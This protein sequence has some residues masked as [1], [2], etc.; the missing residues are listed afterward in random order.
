MSSIFDPLLVF[1]LLLNLFVLGASRLR[2]VVGASAL[3]G[4]CLGVL[5][6]LAHEQVTAEVVI[7]GLI[8]ICFKAILIPQ[9][10]YKAMR[11]VAIARD[12][13]PLIGFI[14]SLVIG[15]IG[16][17]FSVLFAQT[18]PVVPSFEGSLILPAS[19]ATVLTG[20]LVVST[21]RKAIT[22]VVGYLI[23]E[24]G[25][26]IMGLGLLDAMP[27]LVEIGVL[28]DL[29]VAIFVMGIILNHISREFGRTDAAELTSLKE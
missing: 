20:C 7:V 16:T 23:L 10:L 1:V 19:F 24:N 21:R 22:Q 15:A 29:F 26:F 18:L 2:A 17:T 11:D 9:L 4:I 3:Q 13:E 12:V 6:I 28:L 25:I 5:A 14:P 8:A 27:F